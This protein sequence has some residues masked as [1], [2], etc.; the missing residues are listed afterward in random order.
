MSFSGQRHAHASTTE[1]VGL[2]LRIL[3][4]RD[5]V[6]VRSDQLTLSGRLETIDR[7]GNFF[8]LNCDAPPQRIGEIAGA[9]TLVFSVA[10]EGA[11]IEFALSGNQ[12][13]VAHGDNLLLVPLPSEVVRTDRRKHYR[14]ALSADHPVLCV[15]R[16]ENQIEPLLVEA[17]D[18]SV[19]GIGLT[20]PAEGH[21]IK[22]GEVIREVRLNLPKVATLTVTLEVCHLM[23]Q[24]QAL[25]SIRAGCA[26][27]D[28]AIAS[29]AAIHRYITLIELQDLSQLPSLDFA[30]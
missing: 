21:A 8:I 1:I 5:V 13:R 22:A 6:Q 16:L 11:R 30:G 7:K 15:L 17:F 3:R 24:R 25:P 12:V 19:G 2:L 29:Q 14:V 4:A 10:H 20:F 27:I 9:Q 18:L 26:F 28:L 23:E